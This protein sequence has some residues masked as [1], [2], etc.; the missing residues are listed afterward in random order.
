MV[1]HHCS[2]FTICLCITKY[3]LMPCIRTRFFGLNL[4]NKMLT[5][6]YWVLRIRHENVNPV[7]IFKPCR[8]WTREFLGLCVIQCQMDPVFVSNQVDTDAWALSERQFVSNMD[9]YMWTGFEIWYHPVYDNFRV[10]FRCSRDRDGDITLLYLHVCIISL[11]PSWVGCQFPPC[12][13]VC[14]HCCRED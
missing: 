8:T 2:N 3:M 1:E 12:G 4:S 7:F 14:C 6:E 5:R 10:F 13:R 11:F 9:T